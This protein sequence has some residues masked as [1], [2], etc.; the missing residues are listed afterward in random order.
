MLSACNR[1]AYSHAALIPAALLLIAAHKVPPPSGELVLDAANPVIAVEIAGVPL[2]L[3]VDLDQR[4]SI[5]LNPAV[6]SRLT[7][8]WED[9]VPIDV[10]RVSLRT[11]IARATLRIQGREVASQV[12]EHGRDCCQGSD[13][14]A[15]PDIL[16]FA[17]VRWRRSGGPA[18]TGSVTLPLAVSPIYGLSAPADTARLRL[19]FALDQPDTVG[20]AAAAAS[21]AQANGGHW[22]GDAGHV[23]AAFGVRRPARMIAF[24]R[25]FR[26]AGFR[27]DRILVRISDFGGDARLPT[28]PI[29][30]GDIVVTRRLDRQPGW[31]VV[32]IGAD[33][34]SRCA[35]IVYTAIP[36]TLTLRCAFDGR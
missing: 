35:E 5:E 29:D 31:P 8:K 25:S 2:R 12:S 4:E 11:R 24:D 19:R 22:S 17:I 9:D 30:A 27:F 28:D 6:A 21:L 3:R 33:R 20:T 7:L 34:L 13:G 26:L 23:I 16:P 15:G 1:P 14:V 18:S 36:R 32:T 10:G